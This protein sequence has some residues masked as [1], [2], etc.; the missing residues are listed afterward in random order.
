MLSF[1]KLPGTIYTYYKDTDGTQSSFRIFC[2]SHQSLVI[3]C[4]GNKS[5]FYGRS[6]F[7]RLLRRDPLR[8][9]W[10]VGM[11]ENTGSLPSSY[12]ARHYK[13]LEHG[14][15]TWNIIANL[16]NW[17]FYHLP[18]PP[19]G[20]FSNGSFSCPSD[21]W[22]Y[23]SLSN[24][25]TYSW[26]SFSFPVSPSSIFPLLIPLPPV[27]PREVLLGFSTEIS[28]RWDSSM[29]SSMLLQRSCLPCFFPLE[30]WL[31]WPVLWCV[32]VPLMDRV[33]IL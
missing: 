27:P 29:E 7:F 32:C 8:L 14:H 26:W 21:F 17:S 11:S 33:G 24:D 28:T 31:P 25:P 3:K 19:R 6:F 1:R 12:I 22:G 18:L 4:I 30:G 10:E 23:V 15:T 2:S 16:V 20:H 5:H 13:E 9:L